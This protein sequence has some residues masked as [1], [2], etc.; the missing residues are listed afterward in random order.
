MLDVGALRDDTQK[1][2]NF[3]DV[4]VQSIALKYPMMASRF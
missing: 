2:G 4:Y 3:V 1:E